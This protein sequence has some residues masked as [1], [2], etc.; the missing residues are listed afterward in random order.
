[1][2]KEK[3]FYTNNVSDLAVFVS[4]VLEESED[5]IRFL[6]GI[7]CKYNQRAF[8]VFQTYDLPKKSIQDWYEL[9]VL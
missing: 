7:Y 5:R 3:C 4:R 9:E 6:G 8:E 2:L 1:M